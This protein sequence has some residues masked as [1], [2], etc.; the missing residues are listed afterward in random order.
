MGYKHL[1][2][3]L[4]HTLWDHQSNA[5][6]TLADLYQDY[7]LFKFG[8]FSERSFQDTFHKVNHA[9]WHDYHQGKVDQHFIRNERFKKV[10]ST[11]GV[12]DFEEY[13]EIGAAYLHR[14]P[15][16]GYLMPYTLET[17]Q[18]LDSRYSMTIITNGF[19][20]VQ[21]VKLANSGISKYFDLVITSEKAG[22]LKPHKGI[23]D[24]ALSQVKVDR[25]EC[26]MIGDNPDTD[27]SGARDAGIDQIY[28]N[29]RG[30]KN[31]Q[32]ATFNI[33]SLRDLKS[34]L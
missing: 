16:K 31:G 15:R 9:L 23:F 22:W 1:F 13:L 29:S 14:C 5:D 34:L 17:L 12:T 32:R 3:D 30:L 2:F 18:Y 20:E 8:A 26:V 25:T 7:Q 33:D 21:D 27:I 19:E 24:Y 10:L 4:D 11:L 6:E 28:Y